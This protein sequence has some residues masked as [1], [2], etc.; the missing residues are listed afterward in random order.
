MEYA[1]GRPSIPN[2]QPTGRTLCEAA[3][4]HMA[5][6]DAIPR[7]AADKADAE[8]A[9]EAQ[10]CLAAWVQQGEPSVQGGT[11]SQAISR[12]VATGDEAAV[13]EVLQQLMHEAPSNWTSI[14]SRELHTAT[15]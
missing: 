4:D 9:A 10:R 6:L 1:S 11:V 8:L 2:G 15:W 7:A 12:S 3:R 13:R 5:H 14:I